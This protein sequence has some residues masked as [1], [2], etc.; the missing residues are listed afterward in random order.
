[1]I[2]FK[3]NRENIFL[4]YSPYHVL[5]LLFALTDDSFKRSCTY[6]LCEDGTPSQ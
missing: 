5:N 3:N 2:S 6:F 1:M 4:E